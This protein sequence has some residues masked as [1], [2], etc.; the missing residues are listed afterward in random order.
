MKTRIPVLILSLSFLIFIACQNNQKS[1]NESAKQLIIFH[2][3]S[4]SVPFKAIAEAFEKENPGTEVMLEPAGSRKCARKIT[5]LKRECDIMAS[6]DYTVID[7]QLIPDYADWNIK[8]VS[9]EM[10]IVYTEKS[11]YSAE[12][13]RNNWYKILAK[14]DV[15]IG[16]SDPNSDPCGYRAVLT[17]RLADIYYHDSTISQILLQ[18]DNNFIRP[19]ETDLL[20]LLESNTL[21]YIF[22]YRSVAQQ[23]HLKYLLLPDEIN[24]KNTAFTE[25]YHTVNVQISGKKPGEF[26]TKKGEPMVYGITILKNAPHKEIAVKFVDFVLSKKGMSI[27]EA[28]GQPSMIPAQVANYEKIPQELR[29]YTTH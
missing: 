11:K 8:F 9:N 26:I 6:A 14:K 2:A 21:D 23:H 12:I 18:K 20:A 27:L 22:L 25:L 5:D 15:F 29:I 16:R 13:N 1:D 3:G 7:E 4:L 17:T 19:K 24:L 28:N 10:A